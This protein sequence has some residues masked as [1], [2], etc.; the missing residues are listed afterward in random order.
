MQNTKSTVIVWLFLALALPEMALAKINLQSP[1]VGIS[2]GVRQNGF[3]P[4]EGDNA[5]KSRQPVGELFIGLEEIFPNLNLEISIEKILDRE[6]Q[7]TLNNGDILCGYPVGSPTGSMN[8]GTKM[9]FFSAGIDLIYKIKPTDCENFSLLFG[10]GIKTAKV[11]LSARNIDR[12]TE[13]LNSTK[14]NTKTLFKFSGG[15]EYMV[16]NNCGLRCLVAWENTSA[17]Q[18][19]GFDLGGNKRT[20]HLKNTISYKLGMLFKF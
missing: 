2:V 20:A 5:F 15:Y 19:T 17:L 13:F 18:V 3:H 14:G 9:K 16:A 7:F 4:M 11:N 12:G 8:I 1:Y 10:P 6:K